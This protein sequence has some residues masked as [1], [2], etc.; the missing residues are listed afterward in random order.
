MFK[1]LFLAALLALAS[2]AQA[3]FNGT[4]GIYAL[5]SM[6]WA[7]MPTSIAVA[8]AVVPPAVVPTLP[9][10]GTNPGPNPGGTGYAVNDTITLDCVN[11][12]PFYSG[13]NPVVTVTT[14]S[15][16]KITGV[17]LTN[18]GFAGGIPSSGQSGQPNGV[19]NF[20]QIATSGSGH[21]AVIFGI[22]GPIAPVTQSVN[23]GTFGVLPVPNGGTGAGT[24]TAGLP[25]L[26]NG[27]SAFIQG[28]ISGT[29]SKFGTVFGSP[30]NGNCAS[31]NNGNLI[32]S[33]VAGCGTGS[34]TGTI[35]PGLTGQF[36]AYPSNGTTVAGVA[37]PVG[38]GQA[39]TIG[40]YTSTGNAIVGIT[41]QCQPI[42]IYGGVGDGSTD[43]LPAINAWLT[44]IGSNNACLAFPPGRYSISAQKSINLASGQHLSFEGAGSGVSALYW[45]SSAGGLIINYLTDISNSVTVEN[46]AFLAGTTNQGAA[47]ILSNVNQVF[48]YAFDDQNTIRNVLFRGSDGPA[49]TNYWGIGVSV[50]SVNNINFTGSQWVGPTGTASGIGVSLSGLGNG[51][52]TNASTPTSSNVIHFAATPAGIVNGMFFYDVSNPAAGVGQFQITSFTGTTVTLNSNVPS[53]VGSGDIIIFANAAIGYAFTDDNFEL[54]SR[55][56]VY[57]NAVQGVMVD[58]GDFTGTI[59]GITSN[60]NEVGLVQ[61]TVTGSQ[62]N[63]SQFNI[64]EGS[65]I[66]DTIISNNLFFIQDTT[67]AFPAIT[68]NFGSRFTV[69]GNS[70]VGRGSGSVGITIN[71]DGAGG[72]LTGNTFTALSSGIGLA[73]STANITISTNNFA[74]VTTHVSNG[75]GTACPASGAGN[76]IGTATP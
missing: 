11:S 29:G 45:P 25:I 55:G 47:L 1:R 20:N 4:N 67:L 64:L 71:N 43:N 15:G 12:S 52:A 61:L 70:I 46:L 22:F 13:T 6:S 44:A 72:V 48:G 31:W 69:T 16:G 37:N 2:P 3:Q 60:A 33:G 19:C 34:P 65:A 59:M 39:G 10:L 18:A 73:A 23:F 68:F 63:S 66:A 49:G 8:P 30:V 76:C 50:L 41:P 27:T 5:N 26:G 28:T 40:A 51:G 7:V 9:Y 32:D 56:I 54:L 17:S 14:V 62:F 35:T 38:A 36:A 58:H 75:G 74:S 57:G 21:G 53:T 24:F 42:T